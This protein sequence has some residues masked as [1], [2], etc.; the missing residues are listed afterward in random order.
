MKREKKIITQIICS[1]IT[2]EVNVL[3]ELEELGYDENEITQGGYKITTTLDYDA[4]VAANESIAKNLAA[5][6]LTK[7][8][9]NAALF[10]FSPMNG[11]IIAYCGG[12]DY[13]TSQYFMH[14]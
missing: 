2:Q 11:A 13:A 8:K 14:I 4:Q 5:W 10:T 12:K 7:S 9:Q 6:K 3:K 1:N